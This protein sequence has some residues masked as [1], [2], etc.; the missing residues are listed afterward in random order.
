MQWYQQKVQKVCEA[1]GVEIERGIDTDAVEGLLVTH[2]FNEL[3]KP[4]RQSLLVRFLKQF[5]NVLVMALMFAAAVSFLVGE[6][7]DAIVIAII[8]L[9]NGVL[10]FVQEYKAEQSLEALKKMSASKAEVI[11]SG[12]RQIIDVAR[13]VPGDIVL[14]EAGDKVPADIRL[15]DGFNLMFQEAILT[16]ESLPVAKVFTP[17]KKDTVPLGDQNNMAFKDTIV[18]SG[19]GRGIVIA[20]GLH[21]E[22]GKI[23]SLLTMQEEK[24]TPLQ[25]DLDVVGRR[26]TYAAGLIIGVVFLIGVTVRSF[27]YLEMFLTSVALAVAAI[28]E[29]LPAVITIVLSI[30]VTRMAKQKAI[31]KRLPAVETLGATGI[32]CSDKTG[33]LTQNRIRVVQIVLRDRVGTAEDILKQ[34]SDDLQTLLYN[35]VLNSTAALE[36]KGDEVVELG[37]QTEVALLFAAQTYGIHI[38]ELRFAN[39][40]EF[41]I[42]FDSI[43]KYSVTTVANGDGFIQYIKGAPDVLLE[44]AALSKEDKAYWQE[45]I[46]EMA[47]MGLRTLAFGVKYDDCT[48]DADEGIKGFAFTGI[49]GQQDPL[50]EEVKGAIALAHTAGIRT[51]MIT[52]DHKLTAV[53]I[54]KELGIVLD[55]AEAMS[56][57]EVSSLS[58][59]KLAKRLSETNIFARVSPEQKLRLVKLFQKETGKN[60]AVTGDGV[61]DAPAIKAAD[62]GVAMG[63][64]GTDV[65]REVADLVLEDDNFATIVSAVREGR[66]IYANIV[67]FIRY[68]ISCN[69]SEIV[70]VFVAIVLGYPSP[71]LPIQLL[72]VNLVTDGLPALALGMD[73]ADDTVM[74]QPPRDISEGILTKRRWWEML[75][76]ALVIGGVTLGLFLYTYE[77]TD[78]VLLADTVAFTTL[79]LSQL[80]HSLN[81][82]SETVSIFSIGLFSNIYLVMTIMMS[83]LLQMLVVYTDIGNTLFDATD[84]PYG[85]MIWVFLASLVPVVFVEGR[86]KILSK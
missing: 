12:K 63:I 44:A 81:Q 21:T 76:E 54:G 62:I 34:Q 29:G 72:W 13:L 24:E 59:A 80:L 57:E 49:V 22:V 40:K 36:Y 16:G 23:S 2:G 68:L 50:R 82:R 28:P 73:G 37:D 31:V 33:T 17:I 38:Q 55:A 83:F 11:R 64:E 1:F 60:V 20:T 43:K 4:E 69:L 6:E 41:S 65:T 84:I 75:S 70:V 71:L 15:V 48:F 7:F 46:E 47:S 52:G 53:A 45:H 3:P 66:V 9:L 5:S 30:G 10:G 27:G 79:A 26:L 74:L 25:H 39:K 85:L 14:L 19:E 67:K 78:N 18:A 56:G 77:T 58:D 32:I 86:K 8:V 35:G 61:N 51:V 42:P